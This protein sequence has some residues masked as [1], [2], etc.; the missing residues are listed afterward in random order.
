MVVAVEVGKRPAEVVLVVPGGED[1]AETTHNPVV[2]DCNLC[3]RDSTSEYLMRDPDF[4][5]CR[6]VLINQTV[7]RCLPRVGCQGN[8]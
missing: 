5:N 1:P 6:Q 2:V 7:F 3:M 4:G 8:D